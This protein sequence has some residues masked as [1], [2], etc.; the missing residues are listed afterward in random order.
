M[1]LLDTSENTNL[2][3]AFLALLG[4]SG[5]VT[6]LDSP[7]IGFI[8]IGSAVTTGIVAMTIDV[9]KKVSKSLPNF[10]QSRSEKDAAI[11]WGVLTLLT[12]L[13][14]L[15]NELFIAVGILV[16]IYAVVRLLQ[17]GLLDGE[18]NDGNVITF[19]IEFG[20]GSLLVFA[21]NYPKIFLIPASLTFIKFL[22]ELSTKDS[23]G[24]IKEVL[25]NGR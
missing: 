8:M 17:S 2:V 22:W 24:K 15:V 21:F 4:F 9:K 14:V 12:F 23:R 19:A 13:T 5:I 7:A 20:L 3:V 16:Q 10:D 25:E 18:L 11:I 6:A 1:E